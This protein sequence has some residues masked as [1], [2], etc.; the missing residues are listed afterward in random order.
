MDGH[1]HEASIRSPGPVEY[2]W[3]NGGVSGKSW[4][5]CSVHQPMRPGWGFAADTQ[6]GLEDAHQRVRYLPG[7]AHVIDPVSIHRELWWGHS[8]HPK[9]A[10]MTTHISW[11]VAVEIDRGIQALAPGDFTALSPLRGIAFQ[12]VVDDAGVGTTRVIYQTL[13]GLFNIP[14]PVESRLG[15]LGVNLG[16]G[17]GLNEPATFARQTFKVG[18]GGV[19]IDVDFTDSA[20]HRLK[21]QLT[22]KREWSGF[23]FAAPPGSAMVR[24]RSLFIP[25]LWDFDFMT[26]PN[27]FEASFDDEPL[28]HGRL[29]V[30]RHGPRAWELTGARSAVL[31]E[32]MTS[33]APTLTSRHRGV[34]ADTNNHLLSVRLGHPNQEVVLTFTEPLPHLGH[35]DGEDLDTTWSLSVARARIASGRWRQLKVGKD[36]DVQIE[37]TRGWVGA[38]GDV[39]M[40]LLTRLMRP[41]RN[42]P[43]AYSFRGVIRRSSGA[44]G[45]VEG[46]WSNAEIRH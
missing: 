27:H 8:T 11:P 22:C 17:L 3:K 35:V 12:R 15:P 19:R 29:S 44:P 10:A 23:E 20:G 25:Y 4:P 5:F 1:R 7:A 32:F 26:S 34:Q 41:L 46:H 6:P 2:R 28:E 13:D 37:V 21:Y 43:T 9:W 33:G 40:A 30:L 14:W 42:W 16:G 18:V 38:R 36:L 31:V 39:G 45:I 24:P